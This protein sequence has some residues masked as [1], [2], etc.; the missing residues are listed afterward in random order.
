MLPQQRQQA[1]AENILS[2]QV[3]LETQIGRLVI[4]VLRENK[5]PIRTRFS[6]HEYRL[7]VTI[8]DNLVT[9]INTASSMTTTND[10]LDFYYIMF[11]VFPVIYCTRRRGGDKDRHSYINFLRKR[12]E[13]K[14]F[15]EHAI[16]YVESLDASPRLGQAATGEE[17]PPTA[18]G[19]TTASDPQP[20]TLSGESL[21]RRVEDLARK[22]KSS[23]ALDALNPNKIAPTSRPA[24]MEALRKLH[25]PAT[26]GYRHSDTERFCPRDA[27]GG[28]ECQDRLH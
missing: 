13:N 21:K 26:E 20:A 7:L 14:N 5:R 10:D 12:A 24:V 18:G 16:W 17:A 1:R 23:Q 9:L 4:R 2:S 8:M 6:D 28:E 25:P 15:F 3:K 19:G 22:S 11:T 27:I